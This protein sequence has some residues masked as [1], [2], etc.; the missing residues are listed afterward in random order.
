MLEPA[1]HVARCIMLHTPRH[2]YFITESNIHN[3]ILESINIV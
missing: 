2:Y 1:G 3:I